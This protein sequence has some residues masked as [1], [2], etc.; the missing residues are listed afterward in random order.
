MRFSITLIPIIVALLGV[1]IHLLGMLQILKMASFNADLFM[2]IIDALVVYG[3]MKRRKWGFYLAIILFIQQSIM[4][5]N[6]AYQNY[7][8]GFLIVHPLERLI[9]SALVLLSL[10]IL[11]VYRRNY[12]N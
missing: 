4:Q 5:P 3:L 1:L 12:T 11:L 2:F 9:P 8:N 10:V 7:L 6:W